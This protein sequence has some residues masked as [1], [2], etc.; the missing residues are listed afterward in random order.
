M[1]AIGM[2]GSMAGSAITENADTLSKSL[3]KS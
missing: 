1:A 3:N 2:I